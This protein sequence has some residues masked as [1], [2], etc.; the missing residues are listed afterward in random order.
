MNQSTGETHLRAR[1]KAIVAGV[2]LLLVCLTSV[3]AS[4]S[5]AHHFL[6]SESDSESHACFLTLLEKGHGEVSH[7]PVVVA[8]PLDAIPCPVPPFIVHF[9]SEDLTLPSGRGPP[10]LS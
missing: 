5:A 9:A 6:H 7:M 2:L 4:S 8:A 10:F 3:A 1:A